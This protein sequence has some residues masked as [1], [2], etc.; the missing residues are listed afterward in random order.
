MYEPVHGSAPDIAGQG[1]ANPIACILS[2]AMA[3]RYSFDEGA[4]ADL[5]EAAVETRSGTDGAR[6]GDL[7]Q[8]EG[9]K[10]PV[11]TSPR[12]AMPSLLRSAPLLLDP[13]NGMK[14]VLPTAPKDGRNAA[15]GPIAHAL[16]QQK[17]ASSGTLLL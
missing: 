12:W 15:C 9:P 6:T 14:N 17:D 11:S 1:K 13:R 3:L 16:M 10:T 4:N 8:T 5:L 2:F 7:L